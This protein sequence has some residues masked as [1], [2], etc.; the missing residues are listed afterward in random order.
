MV[1]DRKERFDVTVLNESAKRN[2]SQVIARSEEFYR[3][4]VE[5]VADDFL[6]RIAENR[7]IL[8]AGPS[9]SGKQPHP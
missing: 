7:I 8:L 4:Q 6:G 3:N 1:T 9:S 5:Q 2:P